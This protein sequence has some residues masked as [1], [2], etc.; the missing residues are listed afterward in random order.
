MKRLFLLSSILFAAAV[1]VWGQKIEKIYTTGGETYE[2]YICEQVPGEYICVKTENTTRRLGWNSIEKT[3]KLDRD[4]DFTRGVLDVVVLKTGRFYK[5]RIVETVLGK[6]YRLELPDSS[7]L[8]IKY[9][10]V[11][12]ISSEPA[13]VRSSLWSQVDMLDRIDVRNGDIIEGFI[14]ARLIG[15]SLTIKAK[16]STVERVVPTSEIIKYVKVPNPDY[17]VPVPPVKKEPEKVEPPTF[18][19]KL[20]KVKIDG[21]SFKPVTFTKEADG[22]LVLKNRNVI[23]AK[24]RSVRISVPVDTSATIRPEIIRLK[25]ERI[26]HKDRSRYPYYKAGDAYMRCGYSSAAVGKDATELL[27]KN[28]EPG[29]YLI[30]PYIDGVEAAVFEVVK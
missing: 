7:D 11:F 8:L 13:D 4:S 3:E 15:Q 9:D 5:G 16:D 28:L 2:G 6:S 19:Q 20:E 29:Y 1:S 23:K 30:L 17:I 10:N 25:E 27:V 26:Y 18:A 24:G 22:K 12:S 21:A 14:V